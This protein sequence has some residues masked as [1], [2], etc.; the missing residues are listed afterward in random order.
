MILKSVFPQV[1][2]PKNHIEVGIEKH[3]FHN[4]KVPIKAEFLGHIT[5]LLF[6]LFRV[7]FDI[8]TV[9][10]KTA[11]AGVHYSTDNP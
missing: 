7:L 10:G 11:A 1:K 6:Y 2:N 9:Y 3:V 4:G 5:Y 8:Y